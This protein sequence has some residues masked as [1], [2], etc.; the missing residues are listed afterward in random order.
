M[1]CAG[2][3][4]WVIGRFVDF[5]TELPPELTSSS[6]EPKGNLVRT[7]LLGGGSSF[8]CHA[9]GAR[10]QAD[11]PMTLAPAAHIGMLAAANLKALTKPSGTGSGSEYTRHASK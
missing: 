4:R 5:G 2:S 1:T 10:I 9:T 3:E 8:D 7:R 11:R 6:T